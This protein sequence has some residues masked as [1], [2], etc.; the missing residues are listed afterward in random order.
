MNS[1]IGRLFLAV[2]APVIL[3]SGWLW[4]TAIEAEE[5]LREPEFTVPERFLNEPQRGPQVDPDEIDTTQ[6]LEPEPQYGWIVPPEPVRKAA[7]K[8]KKQ[9][10]KA[11]KKS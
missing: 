3:L 9:V 11:V 6:I 2:L 5:Q 4:M 8:V 7:G 1:Q 10:K